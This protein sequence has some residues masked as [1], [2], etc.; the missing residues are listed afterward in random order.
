LSDAQNF[1]INVR[2]E[3]DTEPVR[4]SLREVLADNEGVPALCELV[5]SLQP[6]GEVRVSGGWIYT[7]PV[8]SPPRYTRVRVPIDLK[9][10]R[11]TDAATV[12]IDRK[13]LTMSIRPLRKRTVVDL[14]LTEIAERYL[15]KQVRLNAIA[16]R[17]A[18]RARR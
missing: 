10:F 13:R 3:D 6:G 7:R 11:G 4:T 8:V 16:K 12:T 2:H 9:E 1:R 15:A 5:S 17:N 14:S 18:R